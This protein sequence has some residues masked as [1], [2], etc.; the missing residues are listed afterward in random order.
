MGGV[1]GEEEKGGGRGVEG[2]EGKRRKR[3]GGGR[4]EE[5]EEGR[6]GKRGGKEG[7]EE[8]ESYRISY[9]SDYKIKLQTDG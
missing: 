9:I 8:G 7:R 5:G 3:G 2:G 1:E 4:G 6:R